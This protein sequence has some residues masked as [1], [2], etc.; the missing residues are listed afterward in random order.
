MY[1]YR[2]LLHVAGVRCQFLPLPAPSLVPAPYKNHL[3]F[4]ADFLQNQATPDTLVVMSGERKLR[5]ATG[6][7]VPTS[8]FVDVQVGP[9]RVGELV[10][11]AWRETGYETFYDAH[12]THD[13][14]DDSYGVK[15]V[16]GDTDPALSSRHMIRSNGVTPPAPPGATLKT[17]RRVD[18]A[19][20]SFP[21]SQDNIVAADNAALQT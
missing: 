20:L 9:L 14:G 12:I 2:T 4:L 8:R 16:D 7:N 1:Q 18:N 13:H 11:A 10:R 17:P 15:F 5:S 3:N 6:V 21:K 19:Q